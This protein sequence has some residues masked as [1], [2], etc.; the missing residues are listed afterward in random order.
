LDENSRSLLIVLP[1]G[2]T[3]RIYAKTNKRIRFEIIHDLSKPSVC[4]LLTSDECRK[5]TESL[6]ELLTW[7]ERL[8]EDAA[9]CLNEV[10]DYIE[11]FSQPV[12]PSATPYDLI[13]QITATV[14]DETR[15][16]AIL[17]LLVENGSVRIGRAGSPLLADVQK[18]RRKGILQ[19]HF[20][21]DVVTPYYRQALVILQRQAGISP[22][23]QSAT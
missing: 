23:S 18:L 22:P 17:D 19:Q 9:E 12:E 3:L 16:K 8:A 10:F 11:E 13:F 2:R 20:R 6:D 21:A 7:F 4:R 5:T 15:A 1:R 14:R